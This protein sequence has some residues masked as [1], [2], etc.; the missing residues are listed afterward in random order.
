[1]TS[2]NLIYLFLS[3][4]NWQAPNRKGQLMT[5]NLDII[6]K[7]SNLVLQSNEAEMPVANL[8]ACGIGEYA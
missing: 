8:N 3:V 6:C 4:E 5:Y 2:M 7:Q 1:M